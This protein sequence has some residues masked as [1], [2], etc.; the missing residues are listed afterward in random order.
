MLMML[1]AINGRITRVRKVTITS[2]HFTFPINFTKVMFEELSGSVFI[3]R[4]VVSN[5]FQYYSIEL[6]DHVVAFKLST[7]QYQCSP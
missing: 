4:V 1:Q 3:F 7:V 5:D 6:L 2:Q